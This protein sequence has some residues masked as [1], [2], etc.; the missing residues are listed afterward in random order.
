MESDVFVSKSSCEPSHVQLVKQDE[1]DKLNDLKYQVSV[2]E[3]RFDLTCAWKKA[4]KKLWRFKRTL[5]RRRLAR[6]NKWDTEH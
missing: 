3:G 1:S 4:T 6:Q 2:L 5:M